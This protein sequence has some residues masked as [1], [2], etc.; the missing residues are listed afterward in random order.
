[1]SRIC[2]LIIT[3]S[4]ST[5]EFCP[6]SYLSWIVVSTPWVVLLLLLLFLRSLFSS[7]ECSLCK[8]LQCSPNCQ[9][10]LF[11]KSKT[12]TSFLIYFYPYY[13]TPHVL[14]PSPC[15]CCSSPIDPHLYEHSMVYSTVRSLHC[16]ILCFPG[17][18]PVSHKFAPLIPLR[19][20]GFR[21]HDN[22]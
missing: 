12:T 9:P 20:G 8:T 14:L 1:M 3:S 22:I 17:F 6:P 13:L 15:L 4:D 5:S 21:Q 2:C 7:Q 18:S 11:T 10:L 16:L 19:F